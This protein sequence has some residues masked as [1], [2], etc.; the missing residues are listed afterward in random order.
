VHGMRH[1]TQIPTAMGV[2]KQRTVILETVRLFLALTLMC[3]V[4]QTM[5]NGTSQLTYLRAALMVPKLL[6]A[7]SLGMITV[8]MDGWETPWVSKLLVE[9][10]RSK[11]PSH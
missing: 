2:R 8:A 1:F 7:A 11:L 4:L 6:V 5:A 9:V 10:W 3:G